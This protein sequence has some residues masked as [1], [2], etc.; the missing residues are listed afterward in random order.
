M[1][2]NRIETVHVLPFAFGLIAFAGCHREPR[3]PG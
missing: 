2:G 1:K 3:P